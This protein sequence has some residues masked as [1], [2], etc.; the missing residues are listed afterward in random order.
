METYNEI[1][2]FAQ[3]D[4]KRRRIDGGGR[5]SLFID[6]VKIHIKS[7]DGGSGCVSFRREKYVPRGGP[8]GGDGGKGGNVIFEAD[9]SLSTLID[10]RYKRH[11]KADSGKH[12]MGGDKTGK[13]GDDIIIKVPCGSILKE[14]PSGE[15]LADFIFLEASFR[16]YYALL[17]IAYRF[18]IVSKTIFLS[19]NS[20]LPKMAS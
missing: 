19:R 15:I 14:L 8:N 5:I 16:E 20:A 9:S 3:N 13:N 7:G 1:L 18:L 10:F 12:G 17:K 2:R 4:R 11:Y 6:N